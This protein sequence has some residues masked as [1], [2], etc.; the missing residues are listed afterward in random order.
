MLYSGVLDP[1]LRLA[2]HRDTT[3]D[4][5]VADAPNASILAVDARDV[6]FQLDPVAAFQLARPRGCALALASDCAC[7]GCAS[8]LWVLST[9]STSSTVA[10]Y[11]PLTAHTA[12]CSLIAHVDRRSPLA[13]HCSPLV[14]RN[15][16]A[17]FW[18]GPAPTC[19]CFPLSSSGRRLLQ[20]MASVLAAGA[21]CTLRQSQL[22]HAVRHLPLNP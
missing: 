5:S 3:L 9:P 13:A 18:F 20:K 12:H 1:T 22:R 6:L 16:F 7:S 4:T 17:R 2:P 19:S 11:L 8:M 21:A 15:A 10:E 14:T